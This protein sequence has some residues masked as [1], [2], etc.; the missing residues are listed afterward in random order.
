[1]EFSNGPS[2]NNSSIKVIT[3]PSPSKELQAE[4]E[5][6]QRTWVPSKEKR[7]SLDSN[8]DSPVIMPKIIL[9]KTCKDSTIKIYQI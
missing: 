9:P 5:T 7:A 2:E 1:M 4:L 3:L 6:R 8:D